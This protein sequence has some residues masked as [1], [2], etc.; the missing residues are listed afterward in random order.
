[1]SPTYTEINKW[2]WHLLWHTEVLQPRSMQAQV[3]ELQGNYIWLN[4]AGLAE[5]VPEHP[6]ITKF[7]NANFNPFK[8]DGKWNENM[9][10]YTSF[11]YSCSKLWEILGTVGN[12]IADFEK[13][14]KKITLTSQKSEKSHFDC[15]CV[16]LQGKWK[17]TSSES[18][19]CLKSLQPFEIACCYV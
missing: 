3:L 15:L 9:I 12:K 1:M 10:F 13:E 16:V 19:I 11:V 2:T 17:F 8:N 18:E 4:T 14:E 5:T 6:V 7:Q